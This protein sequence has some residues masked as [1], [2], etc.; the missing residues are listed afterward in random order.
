MPRNKK[1]G[2]HTSTNSP[3][4]CVSHEEVDAEANK[5]QIKQAVKKLYDPVVA[6][7]N[8]LIRSVGEKVMFFWFLIMVLWVLSTKLESSK[9]SPTGYF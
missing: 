7:V 3:H 6:K 2:H 1:L 8:I 9:L 4:H 5:H